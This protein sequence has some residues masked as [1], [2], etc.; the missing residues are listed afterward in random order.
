LSL[1]AVYI[2]LVA[3]LWHINQAATVWTF[4]VPLMVTSFALMFGNWCAELAPPAKLNYA[5]ML[6]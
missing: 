2:A 1:E 4:I 6:I 5:V 3:C